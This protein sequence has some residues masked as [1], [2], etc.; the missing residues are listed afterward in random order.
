MR[1]TPSQLA[2]T[3]LTLDTLIALADLRPLPTAASRLLAPLIMDTVAALAPRH[4]TKQVSRQI[5]VHAASFASAYVYRW[6]PESAEHVSTE[7]AVIRAGGGPVRPLADGHSLALAWRTDTNHVVVD[8]ISLG[9]QPDMVLS[10]WAL[11]RIAGHQALLRNLPGYA[12]VRILVP[13]IPAASM[14][15]AL[16]GQHVLGGCDVCASL[17]PSTAPPIISAGPTALGFAAPASQVP[18]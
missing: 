16:S 10:D 3:E 15:A 17:T 14:H 6:M 5:N 12:G 4:R 9:W 1:P 8:E 11:G 18:R 2:C 13:R 7:L